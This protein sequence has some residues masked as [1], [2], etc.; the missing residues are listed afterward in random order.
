M[1]VLGSNSGNNQFIF[2]DIFFA[3]FLP[4]V[5]ALLKYLDPAI[6]HCSVFAL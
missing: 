2:F 4:P 3:P 5:T 6:L 1:D